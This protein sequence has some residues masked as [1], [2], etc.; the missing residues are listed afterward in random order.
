MF[1]STV[2]MACIETS[3]SENAMTLNTCLPTDHIGNDCVTFGEPLFQSFIQ[4]TASFDVNVASDVSR[5]K[6]I[7][8]ENDYCTGPFV[9]DQE[10]TGENKVI[11][12]QNTKPVRSMRRYHDHGRIQGLPGIGVKVV[13]FPLTDMKP[14]AQFTC[15]GCKDY[16][17]GDTTNPYCQHMNIGLSLNDYN[18]TCA[19]GDDRIYCIVPN[20][21]DTVSW[22]AAEDWRENSIKGQLDFGGCQDVSQKF[23]EYPLGSLY[24]NLYYSNWDS[25]CQGAYCQD[26]VAVCSNTDLLSKNYQIIIRLWTTEQL[27]LNNRG[28]IGSGEWDDKGYLQTSTP[29][30]KFC[31]RPAG[32][33]GELINVNDGGLRT[34]EG[35]AFHQ[36][37]GGPL[38]I[39]R[40]WT[41]IC[42]TPSCTGSLPSHTPTPTPTPSPTPSLLCL[43]AN[44]TCGSHL[45]SCCETLHCN[46]TNFC[47]G[48]SLT[49]SSSYFLLSTITF[50][51]LLI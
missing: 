45:P 40:I 46:K 29:L 37:S 51:F 7:F 48:G 24:Y 20:Q 2:T 23:N 10:F 36:S 25:D 30:A 15:G 31:T 41:R 32:E 47:N 6:F 50:F 8:F 26:T 14:Y 16:C 35:N 21:P 22:G 34:A 17:N 5:T 27:R 39:A 12:L 1:K 13:M 38:S 4:P 9:G 43:K 44:Q 42:E 28:K 11:N 19:S 33:G 49:L 18:D 3:I